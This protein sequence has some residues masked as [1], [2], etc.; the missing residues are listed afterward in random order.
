MTSVATST[1]RRSLAAVLNYLNERLPTIQSAVL[2]T[3]HGMK[4]STAACDADY[5]EGLRTTTAALLEYSLQH[6]AGVSYDPTLIQAVAQVRRAVQ[7]GV[8]IEVVMMRYIAAHGRFS[9][10]V[11]EAAG[12]L[13]TS[14]LRE[15][16]RRQDE[17]LQTL[18]S[19]VVREYRLE[20][21]RLTQSDQWRLE[22]VRSL[23]AGKR[24][25]FDLAYE[26]ND[27]WHVGF[28]GGGDVSIILKSLLVM[29]LEYSCQLFSVYLGTETMWAWLGRRS[30][31]NLEV[32][33]WQV[34]DS[35][36]SLAVGEPAY[37]LD[38]W[39]LTH[40]EAQIARKVAL[41]GRAGVV[42]CVDVLLDSAVL[43]D[44]TIA[45][46]LMTTY[47]VPLDALRVGGDAARQLLM[48]YIRC[49]RR[50]AKTATVLGIT[51]KTVEHRLR[52]IENV[53]GRPLATCI[54]ELEVALRLEHVRNQS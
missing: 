19:A 4:A 14:S 11:M 1:Q 17:L 46:A 21:A 34:H 30:Q 9:E 10:F 35:L 23:L 33:K 43:R 44:E 24:L 38:G 42:R 26:F 6:L 51:R 54:A 2:L 3:T 39:R 40:Q 31:A 52:D 28:I 29:A 20:Q 48:A 18:T 25:D 15:L 53:L 36:V 50:V 27:A 49:Q 13:D 16:C 41:H 45:K 5:E 37:G 47:L 12:E 32:H 22:L 8:G 7:R